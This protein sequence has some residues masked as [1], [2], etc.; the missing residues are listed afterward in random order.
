MIRRAFERNYLIDADKISVEVKTGTVH[1]RGT[2]PDFFTKIQANN[3]A[4]Y[5]TGV[6]DVVDE[7]TIT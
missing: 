5:T 2:V 7:L 3:I 4:I 6:K 1:L